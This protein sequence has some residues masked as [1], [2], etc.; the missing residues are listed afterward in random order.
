MSRIFYLM[1]KSASGKDSVYRELMGR[2]PFKKMIMY[3]TR[4]RRQTEEDGV[5]YYFTDETEYQRLLENGKVIESRCYQTMHGPWIYYT[6]DD[7]TVRR[8]GDEQYLVI[9]TLESYNQLKSYFGEE[10]LVPVYLEVD[11]GL[12]LERALNRERKENHPRYSEM[13]RRYL[14]D[15]KDFSEERLKA[16]GIVRRFDNEQMEQCLEQIMEYIREQI[17]QQG[18]MLQESS[19]GHG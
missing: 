16:A 3:T 1:G 14:A 10:M 17:Q 4:P 15:E 11:D 5:Q 18:D 12:R 2:F 7:G 8:E 19:D 13:C 9:G 6:V